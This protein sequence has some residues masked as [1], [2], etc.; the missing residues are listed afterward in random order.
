[1]LRR[2]ENARV[3]HTYNVF[4][5]KGWVTLSLG[6]SGIHRARKVYRDE[7]EHLAG[8]QRS[9]PQAVLRLGDR[10]YWWFQ[11]RVYWDNDCLN[12]D[13]VRALLVTRDQRQRQQI[14]RAQEIV[15]IGQLP[16]PPRRGAIPDDLKQLVW[17]RDGGRCRIC[18]SQVELQ[19]DHVI[20]LALGGA[21]SAENLQV[22]CGPCNRRKGAAI[23]SPGSP[24]Q[25]QVPQSSA[26]P[27]WYSEPSGQD[28]LRW[29]DGRRWTEHITTTGAVG[30]SPQ[31]S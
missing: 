10:T 25:G 24:Q 13:E 30:D 2:A 6:K 12:A 23:V 19:F 11:D 28:C 14:N 8:L 29:W 5:R 22:L 3:G 27:G 21:T 20:P 17:T 16:I 7:F 1:V 31:Q 15:A 4:T 9:F 18:G 26:A